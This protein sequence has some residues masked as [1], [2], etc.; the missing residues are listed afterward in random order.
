[1]NEDERRVAREREFHNERFAAEGS[2][3][4]QAKYYWAV[5]DGEAAYARTYQ[6]LARGR[7]VLEY[8]CGDTKKFLTLAPIV[9]SLHAIDISDRAIERLRGE[10]TANNVQLHV[11]D[12]MN[13][14]FA[15]ESFDL[16]FGSG[17]IHHL[18]TETSAME[19]ARVLRP[20]GRAV[21]WEP[22][23]LNP[24]IN[25]YRKL[26]PSV[27]TPDEH[28]LLPKD[29]SVFEKY[30]SSVNAQY[31]GLATLAAVPLRNR[32]L[33]NKAAVLTRRLD[34]HLLTLPGVR[35]LAWFVLVTTEK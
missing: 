7:D 3:S 5:S 1:M 15:D 14:T 8:G 22:L 21:F 34:R 33:G 19:I 26:T 35:S 32:S 12:A 23:G 17:I 28:P 13:M 24:V 20:G 2:R 31:Y 18:D 11:M 29:L 9:K 4:N 16:V 25:L 27:R 6:D 10:N 30:F